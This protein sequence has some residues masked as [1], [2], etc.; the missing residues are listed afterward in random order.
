MC[1]EL[2][3]SHGLLCR[4]VFK[5]DDDTYINMPA[6]MH[7]LT[8]EFVNR[9]RFI[10]GMIWRF[11]SLHIQ[12]P[13]KLCSKWCIPFSILP[14]LDHY[15]TYASG[16]FY[17]MT[18]DLAKE[19]YDMAIRTPF[20]WVDDAYMSGIVVVRIPGLEHIDISKAFRFNIPIYKT[21]LDKEPH[22]LIVTLMKKPIELWKFHLP[23]VDKAE[24]AILGKKKTC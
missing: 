11:P 13:G 23:R 12:R 14:G 3:I 10:L 16:S 21:S 18:Q 1:K 7:R 22:T 19:I 15:P 5:S 4:Y 17:V 20:F 2:N 24:L 9:T 8:H 6:L